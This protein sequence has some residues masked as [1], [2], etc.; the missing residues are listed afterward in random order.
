MI[1]TITIKNFQSH[2]ETI[3]ELCDGVNVIVGQSDSGKSAIIRALY[4]LIFNKPNG[5]SF[6]R[7]NVKNPTSVTMTG[8][9]GTISRIKGEKENCYKWN[10]S[11]YRAFG[12]GVPQPIFEALNMGELNFMRQLDPPF[13]FSKSGGELAAFLNKLINLEVIDSSL[14]KIKQVA[15]ATKRQADACEENITR[16]IHSLDD[17]ADID[18]MEKIVS[19]IEAIEKKTQRLNTKLQ[20]LLTQTGHYQNNQ[21]SVDKLN[22]VIAVEKQ[23]KTVH[24]LASKLQ[25]RRAEK[26]RVEK[27]VEAFKKAYSTCKSCFDAK[28]LETRVR[29]LLNDYNKIGKLEKRTKAITEQVKAIKYYSDKYNEITLEIRKLK[30]ELAKIKPKTCPVC[31]QPWE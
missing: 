15:T 2:K 25:S 6:M 19:S 29:G 7:H 12:T 24:E 3:L 13:M 1:D 20:N 23:M 5:N 8:D 28:L 18:N 27:A 10:T 21:E 17:Y 4:W 30:T 9:F 14:A 16:L 31:G 11:T 26:Y 22:W